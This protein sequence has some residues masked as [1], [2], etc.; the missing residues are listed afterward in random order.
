M[1]HFKGG[2]ICCVLLLLFSFVVLSGCTKEN[3]SLKVEADRVPRLQNKAE[4]IAYSNKLD[5]L[6]QTLRIVDDEEVDT[7]VRE[8]KLQDF[9]QDLNLLLNEPESVEMK[10]GEFAKKFDNKL[11]LLSKSFRLK[12][13][14]LNVRI[15]NFRAPNT[16]AG[17]IGGK[18]TFV[19][20]WSAKQ[21]VH[22][23]MLNDDGPEL[24]T[25]FVVRDS[26][27]GIQLLL[28][29]HVS[30]YHPYPVFVALW[31]L[32]GQ[33]WTQKKIVI[34]KVTLSDLWYLNKDVNEPIIFENR[35]HDSMSIEVLDHG[36]GFLINRDD[37]EQNIIIEFSKSG[38]VRID[39]EHSITSN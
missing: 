18:Y 35:Q 15:V 39:S 30:I 24:T 11:T 13:E 12:N 34:D 16:L 26:D 19:Q 10:D 21:L 1:N 14:Q 27:H 32:S 3:S 20:W 29:G 25:D 8:S 22:A 7:D 9:T 17:T 31:E 33:K 23:Q 4:A 5:A 38:E 36:D 28:G 37:S 6:V 2:R